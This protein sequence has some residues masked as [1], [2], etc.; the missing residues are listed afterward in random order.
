MTFG[1]L[2]RII[3][4]ERKHWIDLCRAAGRE[5]SLPLA[6]RKAVERQSV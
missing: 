4:A 6:K 1:T 2:A 5:I 3:T